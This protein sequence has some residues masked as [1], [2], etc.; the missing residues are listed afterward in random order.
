M[1]RDQAESPELDIIT[2]FHIADPHI[3]LVVLEC[4]REGMA[5]DIAQYICNDTSFGSFVRGISSLCAKDL[6]SAAT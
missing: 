3:H 2:G 5:K 6:E 4:L 1:C